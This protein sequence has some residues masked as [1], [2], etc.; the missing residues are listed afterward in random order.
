LL[1]LLDAGLSR[2]VTLVAAPAGYGKTTL[3]SEWAA[4]SGLPVAWLTLDKDDNDLA[5][6]LTYLVAALRQLDASLGDETLTALHAQ[7]QAL[8]D[9]YGV[10]SPLLNALTALPHEAVLVLDD[11]HLIEAQPVH[12]AVTFFCDHQPPPL[13]LVLVTRADPPLPLARLRA[14]GQLAEVRQAELC[15]TPEE[16]AALLRQITGQTIA[17]SQAAALFE[18]T[19]G[20]AAGLQMA[21]ASLRGRDAG[22]Y[23]AFIRSFT[24]THRHV[25]DYLVEEVLQRQPPEVQEFLL[26]TSILQ[27]LNASVCDAVRNEAAI[28]G[29]PS[30]VVLQNLERANLFLTALD[31]QREWYRYHPLFVEL[32]EYRLRQTDPDR[33]PALHHRAAVWHEQNGLIAEAVSHALA[34]GE[35][36]WAARLIEGA[37]PTAWKRGEVLSWARWLKR[38]PETVVRSR[39]GLCVYSAVGQLLEARFIADVETLTQTAA[40]QDGDG[41]WRGEILVLRAVQ[42][43]FRGDLP[44]SIALAQAAV[45]ELVGDNPLHGLAVRTLST[46]LFLSGDLAGG[47]RLLED[48]VLASQRAGDRLGHAV[49]LRRLGTLHLFLGHL[50]QAHSLYQQSLAASR[51]A[52]GRPWPI[53][54]RTLLRLGEVAYLWNELNTADELLTEGLELLEG[55][56]PSWTIGGHLVLAQTRQALQDEAGADAALRAAEALARETDTPLDNL[57]V[58]LTQMQL[59]LRRGRLVEAERLWELVASQGAASRELEAVMSLAFLREIKHA[60]QARLALARGEPQQALE[61]LT[62][63]LDSAEQQARNTSAVEALVLLAQAHQLNGDLPA[64]DAALRRALTLAEPEGYVRVFLDEGERLQALLSKRWET[65]SA[66]VDALR[67]RLLAAF[68]EATPAVPNPAEIKPSRSPL[69]EPLSERELEMLRLIA[70]GL[71]NREI[72]Q[73]L[74]LSLYT[75]KFHIYNLF[76]KL[77]VHSRTQALARAQELGLVSVRT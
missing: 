9:I 77:G 64:A 10:L 1:Q 21:G 8:G 7:P 39:P 38:L 63:L 22:H 31:D 72:A 36:E 45:T 54:G 67:D 68:A 35:P 59:A 62:A 69:I 43:I 12:A 14:R 50:H 46:A 53:A 76:G 4:A 13:H 48:D 33:L 32:L 60:L 28:S 40:E 71:S 18:R 42:A 47:C 73:K 5:R 55:V 52:H 23:D 24:G 41:R 27:R 20:W 15:F 34:A 37:I 25:L 75:I 58:Q 56:L 6:C 65:G 74:V 44:T 19:E 3:V 49:S 29:L 16:A 26:L 57:M 61:V 11:Y 51:D 17:E 70:Q 30:A 66:R 2:P